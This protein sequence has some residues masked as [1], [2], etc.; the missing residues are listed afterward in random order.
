MDVG[1][2]NRSLL[3]APCQQIAVRAEGGNPGESNPVRGERNS[4]LRPGAIRKQPPLAAT[5]NA[6]ELLTR[7]ADCIVAC[8]RD[9]DFPKI[10]E[11]QETQTRGIRGIEGRVANPS[12][13]GIKA[14]P[15]IASMPSNLSFPS[16]AA[17]GHG[18]HAN[19]LSG[20]RG[21]VV[22][23][24]ELLPARNEGQVQHRPVCLLLLMKQDETS[25]CSQFIQTPAL[26]F[27]FPCAF[28]AQ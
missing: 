21:S 12:A 8:G 13:A 22:P 1:N 4:V 19:G 18:E 6:R 16:L 15:Q 17:T 23:H 2:Q 5:A 26:R 14:H 10:R 11:A 3:R 27:C 25:G 9:S 7:Q 20:S 28:T 24:Q